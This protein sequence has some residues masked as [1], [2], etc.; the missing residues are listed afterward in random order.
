MNPRKVKVGDTGSYQ[1]YETS[2]KYYNFQVTAVISVCQSGIY[3]GRPRHIAVCIYQTT[4]ALQRHLNSFSDHTSCGRCV[5]LSIRK[6]GE[7]A[8]KNLT[9]ER[10]RHEFTFS[11]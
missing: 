7:Y 5:V 4:E 6:N 8:L 3:I 11:S 2:W 9:A 10:W 1:V